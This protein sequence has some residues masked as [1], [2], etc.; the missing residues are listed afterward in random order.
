MTFDD[1]PKPGITEKLLAVLTH[2]GVPATFFVIGRHAAEY[3]ELTRKIADAGMQ[4]EN[5]TYTHPNLTLLPPDQFEREL[6]KTNVAIRTATGKRVRFFRPPGGNMNGDVAKISSK[7]GLTPCMW[8]ID[9][10]SLEAGSPE[11]DRKSVV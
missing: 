1:G 6:L 9:G 3:P 5:H 2:E 8:T 11:R 7:L 4:I 10:E